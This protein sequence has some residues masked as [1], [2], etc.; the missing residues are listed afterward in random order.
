MKWELLLI[1]PGSS[2]ANET[3]QIAQDELIKEAAIRGF[4]MFPSGDVEQI[5]QALKN[6][7]L[8]QLTK[9]QCP[10]VK[11]TFIFQIRELASRTTY[12]LQMIQDEYTKPLTMFPG[13]TVNCNGTQLFVF[14]RLY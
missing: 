2:I 13:D 3:F 14:V 4:T 11:E 10:F 8:P 6:A 12:V 9:N 1:T 5:F 7:G